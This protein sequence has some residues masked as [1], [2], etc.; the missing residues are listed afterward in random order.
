MGAQ[1]MQ[2]CRFHASVGSHH[3]LPMHNLSGSTSLKGFIVEWCQLAHRISGFDESSAAAAHLRLA[4]DP[5]QSG[6]SCKTVTGEQD[7]RTANRIGSTAAAAAVELERGVSESLLPARSPHQPPSDNNR[8]RVVAN[9][10]KTTL[11]T[12][13]REAPAK[14]EQHLPFS[15]VRISAAFTVLCRVFL[16]DARGPNLERVAPVEPDPVGS[17]P[18]AKL[19]VPDQMLLSF[20]FFINGRCLSAYA[21]RGWP[22]NSPSR[23]AS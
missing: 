7:Q 10:Q 8:S 9:E 6:G 18:A 20:W 12:P 17:Q 11:H 15:A 16:R 5:P 13:I 22:S 21:E 3:A 2:K 19:A 4:L 23:I 1:T 14:R